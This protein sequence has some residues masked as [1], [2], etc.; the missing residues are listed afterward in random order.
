M[1]LLPATCP[2]AL[3]LGLVTLDQMVA[4]LASAVENPCRG[5]RVVEVPEIR[6]GQGFSTMPANADVTGRVTSNSLIPK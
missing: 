4:A 1:E 6:S 5:V 2:G 3:R